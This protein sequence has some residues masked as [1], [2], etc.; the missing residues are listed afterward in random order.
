MAI[1]N[2]NLRSSLSKRL[3]IFDFKFYTRSIFIINNIIFFE[4]S[5]KIL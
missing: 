3:K 2:L 5:S 4:F 1:Q